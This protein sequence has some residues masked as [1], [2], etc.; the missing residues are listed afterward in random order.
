MRYETDS[1]A[2]DLLEGAKA[3][4]DFLSEEL[5]LKV[6]TR[7]AFHMCE[8]KQIPAGKLGGAWIGSRR[9]LRGYL[10]RLTAAAS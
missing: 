6:T 9:A 3:I 8:K 5:G 7:R 10:E 1:N 4:A 2:H